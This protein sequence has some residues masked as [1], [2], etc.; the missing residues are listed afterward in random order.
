MGKVASIN[1]NGLVTWRPHGLMRS[2]CQLD[3]TRF[4]FDS[5]TCHLWIGPSSYDMSLVNVTLAEASRVYRP[6]VPVSMRCVKI[7]VFVDNSY[8]LIIR[9]YLLLSF[10]VIPLSLLQF[11]C[12]EKLFR[13]KVDT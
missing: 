12:S 7:D 13:K 10:R 4:P 6:F 11:Q 8:V 5:Q 2:H 9:A 3:L 1:H